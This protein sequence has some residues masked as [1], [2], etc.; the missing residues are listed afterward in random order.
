MAELIE[1]IG[2]GEKKVLWVFDRIDA[3]ALKSTRNLARVRTAESR[4]LH[5]YALMNCDCLVLTEDGLKSLTERVN[6]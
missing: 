4:T 3:S 1:K 5:T 2:L 6:A